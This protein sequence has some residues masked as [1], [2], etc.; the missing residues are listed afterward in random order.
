MEP[1]DC[2][3]SNN[4]GVLYVAILLGIEKLAPDSGSRVGVKQK[5]LM[6]VSDRQAL[7]FELNKINK[8]IILIQTML[9]PLLAT[10]SSNKNYYWHK[11][12]SLPPLQILITFSRLTII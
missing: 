5:E 8:I 10:S 9:P 11:S 2:G 6:S 12:S 4:S 7:R 1:F 3:S